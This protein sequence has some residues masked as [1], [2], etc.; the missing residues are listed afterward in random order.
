MWLQIQVNTIFMDSK[1]QREKKRL[2]KTPRRAERRSL[3]TVRIIGGNMRGRKIYFA[4]AEGLRPT[5]DRIRETLFNWLAGDIAG[6]NCLD[7]F[8]GSGALG[9]EAVSRGAAQ[10]TLVDANAKVTQQHIENQA[11]L[12]ISNIEIITNR[13]EDFLQTNNIK[14]DIVF[15]DPPFEKGFLPEVLDSLIPHLSDN[16]LIYVEQEVANNPPTYPERWHVLKSKKTS[17]FY[18]QLLSFSEN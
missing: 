3:S 11:N 6:A 17:R 13:A 12:N 1:K 18:Y 8:A 16:A 2:K 7:L 5:L 15:L 10:V 14:F 4:E 9:F